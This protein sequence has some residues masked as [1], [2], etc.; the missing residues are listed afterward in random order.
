[1]IDPAIL[2]KR[3]IEMIFSPLGVMTVLLA[4]GVV[5]EIA[6][7][8]HRA[9]RR[10]LLC[11]ALVFLVVF[12]SPVS[13]YLT[14]RLERQFEP[15][16]APPE[17]PRTGSIVVLAG[18]AEDNPGSPIT[19]NISAPTAGCLSEGLRLHRLIPKAKLIMSGGP[20]RKRQKPVAAMMADYLRQMGVP[21]ADLVVEGN[22]LN[23]YENLF[24]VRKLVGTDPFILVAAACDL[25]RAV[26]RPQTATPV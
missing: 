6:R 23:T 8:Q 19:S 14:Y 18:Y 22:S 25:R 3:S 10:L 20:A 26:A 4:A 21:V 1:M 13:E 16:L 24:Q 12:F 9:G 11:G 2:L 17:S 7:P 15:L 5:L